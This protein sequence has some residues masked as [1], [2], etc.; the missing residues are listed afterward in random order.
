MRSARC[1]CASWATERTSSSSSAR[2]TRRKNLMIRAVRGGPVS[3]PALI[4]E[5]EAMKTFWGVKPYGEKRSPMNR[6]ESLVSLAALGGTL[7]PSLALDTANPIVRRKQKTRHAGLDARQDGHRS[8]DEIPRPS[9]SRATSRT[10]IRAGETLT[11]HVS[12][13]PASPFTH[14][15]LPPG[16]L[17]RRTAAG[18]CSGSA[19]SRARAARPARRPEAAARV[20]VGAVRDAD[21]PRRLAERRLPRQ[22]HR[23]ARAARRATSSSSSATTAGPTS[24]S[25]A[26]TTPGRPTTA[27]PTSS[28]STTTARTSG[29]GARRAGQL[30]PALRQV[31]PDLRRP[32]VASARA[33]SCSG[34]FRSPSG[35]SSTATT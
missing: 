33:S 30:R 16:L 22:A 21:D 5:Y 27:G 13:N 28:R 20:R 25:S 11:F 7:S 18:S 14:R 4:A 12:T 6:R 15:H 35:W 26:A 24:C 31:L 29:T 23:R 19:R 32:A 1:A 34:S 10:S 2:S 17:R 8:E 9:R 3:D